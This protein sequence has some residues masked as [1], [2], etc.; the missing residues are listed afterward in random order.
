MCHYV[1][2][3]DLICSVQCALMVYTAPQLTVCSVERLGRAL[4]GNARPVARFQGLTNI[5][6]MTTWW[7]VLGV[8]KT[9]YQ[10]PEK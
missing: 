10:K 5:F 2:M 3:V 1:C 7:Q 9:A 4:K 8:P 6:V